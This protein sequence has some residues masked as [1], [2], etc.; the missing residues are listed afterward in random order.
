MDTTIRNNYSQVF[1]AI[2]LYNLTYI[3]VS[4][5]RNTQKTLED[6]IANLNDLKR[7]LDNEVAFNLIYIMIKRIA[8]LLCL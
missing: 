4:V 3:F 7:T 5:Y 8:N 1:W 2:L 6:D